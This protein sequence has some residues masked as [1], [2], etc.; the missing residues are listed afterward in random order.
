MKLKKYI[1]QFLVVG[2]RKNYLTGIVGIE[3]D[4]FKDEFPGLSI[5]DL[6]ANSHVRELIRKDI[7]QVNKELARFETIKDFFIAPEEFSIENGTLTPSMKLKKKVILEKYKDEIDKL[8]NTI[9]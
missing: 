5:K 8:Y 2:D 3:K 6:A 1:T 9:G 7:E 4:S